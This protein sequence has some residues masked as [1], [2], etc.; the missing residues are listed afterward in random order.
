M[1]TDDQWIAL[2]VY[3][4]LPMAPAWRASIEA[5]IAKHGGTLH[6][7]EPGCLTFEFENVESWQQAYDAMLAM[8]EHAEPC[9]YGY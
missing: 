2:E 1:S 9:G 5:E 7:V 6:Y 8:G 4:S 3:S